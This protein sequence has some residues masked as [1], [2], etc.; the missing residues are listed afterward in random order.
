MQHPSPQEDS[1]EASPT[2]RS[3]KIVTPATG[4]GKGKAS[5]LP[6]SDSEN[7]PFT[8]HGGIGNLSFVD[9]DDD[10]EATPK[11]AT[12]SK[13]ATNDLDGAIYQDPD[14][15]SL[16]CSPPKGNKQCLQLDA[17]NLDVFLRDTYANM[18]PLRSFNVPA[19]SC[20]S[21]SEIIGG[22]E[23]S[24]KFIHTVHLKRALT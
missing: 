14:P 19:H 22:F 17:S 15:A 16:D 8:G 2:K 18:W 3:R 11:K 21:A 12:S 5:L 24:N 6:V 20:V 23:R 4:K 1:E 10:H 13:P 9:S 7:N